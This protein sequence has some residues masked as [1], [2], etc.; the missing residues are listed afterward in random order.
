MVSRKSLDQ[1]QLWPLAADALAIYYPA[2]TLGQIAISSTLSLC[3]L[4]VGHDKT[5]ETR[6]SSNCYCFVVCCSWTNDASVDRPRRPISLR[7]PHG[8]T[9]HMQA[10][11]T[12]RP[13]APA[14]RT[15]ATAIHDF[16]TAERYMIPISLG[17]M[18]GVRQWHFDICGVSSI[19]TIRSSLAA[20]GAYLVSASMIESGGGFW[21]KVQTKLHR[22]RGAA[23]WEGRFL[24]LLC[25][26]EREKE[27]AVWTEYHRKASYVSIPYRIFFFYGFLVFRF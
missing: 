24:W 22:H 21:P 12:S 6:L 14:R 1:H 7:F 17:G 26:W 27:V 20:M 16:T 15:K 13:Q 10:R 18:E 25:A 8:Q 5:I 3:Q 2:A 23:N 11:C 9:R 4:V 19:G